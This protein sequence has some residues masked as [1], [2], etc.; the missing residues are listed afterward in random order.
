MTVS[1]E[2]DTLTF[3]DEPELK[4]EEYKGRLSPWEVL[5]VDDDSDVHSVTT[6]ALASWSYQGRKLSFDHATSGSEAISILLKKNDYAV[7][8]L[9]VVMES[10]LAGLEVADFL[11]RQLRNHQTQI[12]LRT[13]HPGTI[14]EHEAAT[15]Y[16]CNFYEPKSYVTAERL[17]SVMASALSGYNS[18]I[19]SVCER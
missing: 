5:V 9:D 11:R 13:G 7:I 2:D 1:P 4:A 3:M 12:I 10:E 16:G 18:A 17:R 19:T 8:L 14:S 15:Q 6:L